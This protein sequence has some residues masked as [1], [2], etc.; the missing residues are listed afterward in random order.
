MKLERSVAGSFRVGDDGN[1][2]SSAEP[3]MLRNEKRRS[4]LRRVDGISAVDSKFHSISNYWESELAK[5]ED[6][7]GA[8]NAKQMFICL[9]VLGELG[10]FMTVFKT[11]LVKIREMVVVGVY[12]DYYD[13]CTSPSCPQLNALKATSHLEPL[14]YFEV[15]RRLNDEKTQL[16]DLNTTQARKIKELDRL[17]NGLSLERNG[18]R[19]A[20]HKM[21][22][23]KNDLDAKFS[24]ASQEREEFYTKYMDTKDTLDESRADMGEIKFQQKQHEQKMKELV[25]ELDK[26]HKRYGKPA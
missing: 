5:V 12:S 20:L 15:V 16:Q 11:L 7:A 10:K 14:P 21:T 13:L 17:C 6:S 9:R 22:N 24:R 3:S 18:L 19:D 1:R 8:P 23:E 26:L 2:A 25:E 4:S